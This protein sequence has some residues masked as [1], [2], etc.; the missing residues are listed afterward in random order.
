MAT[1]SE[2]GR[3]TVGLTLSPEEKLELDALARRS[4]H[5]PTTLAKILYEHGLSRLKSLGTIEALRA[6]PARRRPSRAK[7]SPETLE[8]VY[9]ALEAILED[10]PSAIIHKLTMEITRL[11]GKFSR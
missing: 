10:A 3:R 9:T 5:T 4:G 1:K 2:A 8:A 6:E 11:G 7:V